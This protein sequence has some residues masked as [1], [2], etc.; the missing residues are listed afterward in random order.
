MLTERKKAGI[1]ITLPRCSNN[2]E[3]MKGEKRMIVEYSEKE[4][5]A[6]YIVA[7]VNEFAAGNGLDAVTSFR[8]LFD[9]NGISFLKE[10][11]DIEHTLPLREAINDITL[12][13]RKNGGDL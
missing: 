8:Y 10:H 9:H 6:H 3:K 5:C 13:C 2:T 1:I 11:Y 4:K 12:I 7:C